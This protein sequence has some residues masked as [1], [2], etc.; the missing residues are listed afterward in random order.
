MLR[1]ICYF[2]LSFFLR[3]TN[4]LKWILVFIWGCRCLTKETLK[5]QHS[6]EAFILEVAKKREI[7]KSPLRTASGDYEAWL[8]AILGPVNRTTVLLCTVKECYWISGA[9]PQGDCQGCYSSIAIILS[10]LNFL[11]IG[12]PVDVLATYPL[13]FLTFPRA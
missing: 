12:Y 1:V 8:W 4:P 7:S 11:W 9:T 10:F 5:L 3:L 13:N 6:A 2:K